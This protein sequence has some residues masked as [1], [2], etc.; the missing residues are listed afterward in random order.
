MGQLANERHRRGVM[1]FRVSLC[2]RETKEPW[3]FLP[4][5]FD[6]GLEEEGRALAR[7]EAEIGMMSDKPGT[8]SRGLPSGVW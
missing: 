2:T 3:I 8:V 1:L 4:L 5:G 7:S 6:L